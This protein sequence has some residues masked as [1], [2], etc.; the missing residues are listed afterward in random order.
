MKNTNTYTGPMRFV[1][2]GLAQVA[3]ENTL[4]AFQGAVNG[5]YEGIE[6]DI[7]MTKD[8]EIVVA[9]DSNF[10]RM[11]LGHPRGGSN[12]QIKD[13]TW[14][15]I[16]K[17]ELPYANH[18]LSEELP[19]H[20]EIEIMA[21][22]PK[23]VMGQI[24]GRDYKTALAEDGRMAHL[25]RFSDFDAWLT[26]QNRKITVEVEIK[27]PNLSK[28]LIELLDNSPNADSYILFS[29][30][31]AYI[32]ELQSTVIKDGKPAGLRLGANIRYLT[33]EIKKKIPKM[34]LF[35]V[36]LNAEAFTQEDVQWLRDR[37]ISVLSNLGDYPEWW[38][39]M[40][41]LGV[42]GFKTNYAAAYTKWWNAQH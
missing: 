36:G 16:R 7:Q 38:E 11:T 22:L 42:L 5:G 34:D 23:L 26:S 14:E 8:G 9:H 41:T 35:E 18:L 1:H 3:P 32:E 17:I 31:S 29:G 4:E 25:M 6:I 10:T 33:E 37:G 13:L 40:V 30:K 19:E 12:C 28:P 15:E 21:I 20:S 27:A 2:R 39:K 24:E